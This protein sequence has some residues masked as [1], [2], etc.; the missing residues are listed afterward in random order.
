MVNDF[1]GS[2][3]GLT[4][5][6][7]HVTYIFIYFARILLRTLKLAV[8][9][10][11]FFFNLLNWTH[12]L[13]LVC[14]VFSSVISNNIQSIT[15]MYCQFKTLEND[16]SYVFDITILSTQLSLLHPS[17]PNFFSYNDKCWT[18]KMEEEVLV[19]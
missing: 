19:S 8:H 6:L 5:F 18:G 2:A 12:R 13:K 9:L 3:T 1:L 7:Q 10:E 14:H 15:N 4:R 16:M 17:I 11:F